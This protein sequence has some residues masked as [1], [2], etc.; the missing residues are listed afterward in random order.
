MR[1]LVSQIARIRA[2]GDDD[3]LGQFQDPYGGELVTRWDMVATPPD[4]LV[5]NYSMLN[6]MLMRDLEEPMFDA[7]RCWLSES[8]ENV[9]TLVVDELHLYRG[10]S[11]AEVGMVIRNLTSRLGLE[12]DSRQF[13]IIATSASLPSDSSGLGYLERFFGVAR[14]TFVIEPGQPR[15]L[16]TP[17][18]PV[19]EDVLAVEEE[20][21]AAAA[22]TGRWAETLAAACVAPNDDKPRATDVSAIAERIF[23]GNTDGGESLR[24][25]MRG[26]AASTAPTIPFRAH[27]MLRGMRGLWACSNTQC[28]EVDAREGGASG[29]CTTLLVRPAHVAPGFLN[30]S[31]ATSVATSASGGTSSRRRK[32]GR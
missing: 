9:F 1:G 26:L 8:A 17:S 14:E 21:L 12:S 6:A 5:T 15:V 20:D 25:M 24:A 4:I 18:C 32:T 31:I 29:S 3:L 2:I 13:R 28:T 11:G 10:S 7:T 19:A 27:I 16:P 23:P 30:S 22:D